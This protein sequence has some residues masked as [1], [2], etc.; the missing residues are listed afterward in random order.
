MTVVNLQNYNS[1]NQK[2]WYYFCSTLP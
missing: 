1:K 2:V